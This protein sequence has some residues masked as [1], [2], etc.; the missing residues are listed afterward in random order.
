MIMLYF[1]DKIHPDALCLATSSGFIPH[2]IDRIAPPHEGAG[3]NPHFIDQYSKLSL[4]NMDSMGIDSLV[5]LDADTLVVHNFDEIFELPY[6]FGAV[7]DVFGNRGF[8]LEFNAGVL[9]VRPD[10]RVFRAMLEAL[11][12]ARYPPEFAEQA[13]LNQFFSSSVVRLPY[14]YNGNLAYKSRSPRMWEGIKGNLRVIHY[15]V[16]KPFLGKSWGKPLPW[17]GVDARVVE[18]AAAKKGFFHDEVTL[19]GQYWDETRRAYELV[20]DKCWTRTTE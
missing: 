4:W 16:A 6:T 2:A 12:K 14:I 5:Y 3:I 11:P 15:T 19:W 13:F 8:I 7:P 17:D 1:P 10:S 20:R 18:V 9:F